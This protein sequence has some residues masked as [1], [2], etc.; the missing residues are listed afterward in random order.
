MNELLLSEVDWEAHDPSFFLFLVDID[1]DA[2]PKEFFTQGVWGEV[3]QSI[4]STPLIELLTDSLD[5]GQTE[6][7]AFNSKPIDTELDDS[8]QLMGDRMKTNKISYP[9]I[10]FWLCCSLHLSIVEAVCSSP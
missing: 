5:T 3:Q 7:D 9:Y 1:Y 8:E 10:D 6:D 2:K 4:S